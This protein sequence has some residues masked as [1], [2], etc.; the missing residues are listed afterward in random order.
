MHTN[1]AS[2]G[3]TSSVTKSADGSRRRLCCKPLPPGPEKA[4]RS[5]A[6]SVRDEVLPPTPPPD[7]P[8]PSIAPHEN[9]GGVIGF[10][11]VVQGTKMEAVGVRSNSNSPRKPHNTD[12]R[13]IFGQGRVEVFDQGRICGRQLFAQAQVGTRVCCLTREGCF[14]CVQP[15]QNTLSPVLQSTEDMST[16]EKAKTRKVPVP[17][18]AANEAERSAAAWLGCT[19]EF[20][21]HCCLWS[22]MLLKY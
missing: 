10:V 3:L 9:E 13:L 12:V 14:G 18:A 5:A 11:K 7:R 20:L 1:V 17:V 6:W 4:V 15:S 22:E 21:V 8:G 19:S 16:I 2:Y